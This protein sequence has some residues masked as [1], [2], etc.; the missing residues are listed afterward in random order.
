MTHDGHRTW[1]LSIKNVRPADAGTYMCQVNTEVVTS[2]VGHINVV[3]KLF[4]YI[5]YFDFR[6]LGLS[7]DLFLFLSLLGIY[8]IALNETALDVLHIYFNSVSSQIL[9]QQAINVHNKWFL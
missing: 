8:Y 1:F 3:G 4:N 9:S 6:L 5:H 7:F 2:Q